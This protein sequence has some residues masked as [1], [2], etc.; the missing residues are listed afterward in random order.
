[1]YRG[2][3]LGGLRRGPGGHR[4]GDRRAG[5]RDA[6]ELRQP[7][8]RRDADGHARGGDAR[9]APRRLAA[10]HH[11]LRVAHGGARMVR[12]DGVGPRREGREQ[13]LV[14]IDIDA[15]RKPFGRLG[16]DAQRLGPEEVRAVVAG[17]AQAEVHVIAHLARRQRAEH[18]AVGDA[19]LQLAHVGQREVRVELGLA[20]EHDL[21]QL[22][23]LGLEVGEQPDLLECRERHR[24]CLV[25]Q[26]HH[27]APRRMHLDQLFL[28]R[29]H[30]LRGIGARGVDAEVDRDRGEHL[31]AREAGHREVDRLDRLGQTLHQH[32]AEHRL[33]AA[34]FARDLH[35]ALARGNRVEQGFERGTPVR[36]REEELGVRG[37]AK[38][39]LA[40]P[41]VFQVHRHRSLGSEEASLAPERPAASSLP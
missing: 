27:R 16:D 30:E 10:L 9:H 3:R 33:A 34:D 11:D 37:D 20:E 24:V 8:A 2:L 22:L 12:R 31:V 25:D 41:E 4:G 23:L 13:G 7:E 32:A 6:H 40:Q 14:G 18:E 17:R 29:A 5:G 19:L 39:R 26:R 38:R 36:A 1:M 15:P 35:H 28:E 21:Q